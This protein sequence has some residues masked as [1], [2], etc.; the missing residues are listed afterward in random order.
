MKPS[1][2]QSQR[3][4]VKAIRDPSTFNSKNDD[5]ARRMKIYQSLF[6]S[7]VNGFVSSALPVLKSII[8]AQYSEQQWEQ[9]IRQFFNQHQCRS[10]YFNEISKEFVEYLATAP[11]FA[12]ELP[13]FS[14]ELAHYEWLELD[15]ATR[16]GDENV[17]FYS[18]GE[19]FAEVIVSPFATLASYSF[20]VHLIGPDHIPDEPMNE[21][22]YYVV[23]R[24]E[25][26]QVQ[27]VHLT[28]MTAMLLYTIENAEKGLSLAALVEQLTVQAPNISQTTL[29][30]GVRHTVVDM[31]QKGILMPV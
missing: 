25:E 26:Y 22:Q 18:S 20:A 24:D 29:V 1:L 27:F 11:D 10:P 30:A 12:F 9:I 5:H 6:F 13:A 28:A 15:V 3:E 2:Q 21:P 19:D 8:V 17:S 14:C 16:K 23:Y 7:N 4:F 31:L